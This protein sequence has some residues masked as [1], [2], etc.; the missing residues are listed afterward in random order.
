MTNYAYT[1]TFH[2][3]VSEF[4]SQNH[5]ILYTNLLVAVARETEFKSNSLCSN[6]IN[7]ILSREENFIVSFKLKAAFSHQG[8]ISVQL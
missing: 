3:P 4:Y 7:F 6:D 1:S 5:T 2:N 8:N